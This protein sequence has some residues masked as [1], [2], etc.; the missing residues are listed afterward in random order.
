[1]P[2]VGFSQSEH[3]L[4]AAALLRLEPADP[5]LR[6]QGGTVMATITLESTPLPHVRRIGMSD[7][8]DALAKGIDDFRALPSEAMFLTIIYPVIGLFLSR[9]LTSNDALPLIYP[10]VAGFALV[11]PFAAV[12]LYELSRRRELGLDSGWLHAFDVF[13]SPARWSILALG[14]L[15]LVIFA[16][17]LGTA[18]TIYARTLGDTPLYS[19]GPFLGRVLTTG[20]GWTLIVVGN[21]VGFLF[22]ALALSVGVVSFPLVLDRHVS[23]PVAIVTS[24]RAVVVNPVT[25]A[26]WGFIVAASLV[27]GSIPFLLGLPIILPVLGHATWH[28]YRHVVE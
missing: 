15:L 25:M 18:Q 5:H 11:G 13:K 7:L 14:V 12:G 4:L 6:E 22:A 20:P 2:G 10:L 8:R 16:V 21:F 19:I 27:V 3:G 23:P 24:I 26:A 28:L 1:M 9:V 17:W